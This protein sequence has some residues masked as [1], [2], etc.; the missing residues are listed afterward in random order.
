MESFDSEIVTVYS[1]DSQ[2]RNPARLARQMVCDLKKSRELA[3][4]LLVRNLNERYRQTAL[5]YTWTLLP[6]L[7]TTFVFTL[8]HDAGH[9]VVGR[10]PVPYGL[11][12]LCGVTLWQAFADAL[13]APLRMVQ[14]ATVMVTRVQFPRE[15]LILAGLGE[16]LCFFA[17]R[18]V[19]LFGALLWFRVPVDGYL[20]LAPV[21]AL[22]LIAL[23]TAIG[24]ILTPFALL[25]QDVSQGLPFMISL[26]MFATPVLYP[27]DHSLAAPVRSLLNPVRPLLDTTRAWLLSE[28]PSLL[29]EFCW[30]APLALTLLL[31]GWLVYRLGLPI[32]IERMSA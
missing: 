4:R 5:R 18:L 25:Y 9:F 6:P 10:T 20:M 28:V 12:V 11:F 8:L 1:A 7:L 24:L 16:V 21:G 30:V 3:W 15:A 13:V 23:G 2:L 27:V 29:G 26:W 19:F 31:V 17:I 14:Q 22:S 32:L